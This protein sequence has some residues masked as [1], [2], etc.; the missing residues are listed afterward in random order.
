[1]KRTGS[2]DHDAQLAED[3]R[4]DLLAG[5]RVEHVADGAAER[6]AAHRRGLDEEDLGD[7]DLAAREAGDELVRGTGCSASAACG[8]PAAGRPCTRPS[9]KNTAHSSL[10]TVSCEYIGMF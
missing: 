3:A 5:E 8:G 6:H 7:E 4:R 10:S 9:L 1:M 2:V